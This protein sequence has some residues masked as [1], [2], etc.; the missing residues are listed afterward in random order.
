LSQSLDY[1]HIWSRVRSWALKLGPWPFIAVVLLV[2]HSSLRFHFAK[3]DELAKGLDV[4]T[5]VLVGIAFIP[6][7]VPYIAAAKIPGFLEIKLQQNQID[8]EEL[9]LI[10][11][12]LLSNSEAEALKRVSDTAS[13]F[14]IGTYRND[15]TSDIKRLMGLGMIVQK[16]VDLPG[17][18]RDLVHGRCGTFRVSEYF[19]ISDQGRKYFD[20]R[21]KLLGG[22]GFAIK[23]KNKD[24]AP[25]PGQEAS[26]D[27]ASASM[28][29][30]TEKS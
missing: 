8:I 29:S 13:L 9:K 18:L 5:I 14:S 27:T 21:H 6:T 17:T 2:A 11:S 15:L 12:C 7:I 26:L 16:P 20:R 23:G 3:P 4:T 22:D 19:S 24:S 10:V 28:T 25:L 1:Q 30:A